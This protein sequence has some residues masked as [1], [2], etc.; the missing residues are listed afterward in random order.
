MKRG[1]TITPLFKG[2]GDFAPPEG[3]FE[4]VFHVPSGHSETTC[5][6]TFG[7]QNYN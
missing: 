3:L 7:M 5:N 4:T 6:R 2:T 1:M